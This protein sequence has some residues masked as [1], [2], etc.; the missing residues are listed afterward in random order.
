MKFILEFKSYKSTYN[1]GDIVLIEYWYLDE[2]DCP[3]ELF[4]KM[5]YTPVKI[6]EKISNKSFK[7]SHNIENSKIKNAPDEI[8]KN[9][10]IIDKVR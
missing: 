4:R 6:I 9:N 7:V 1:V 10:D 2:K 8:I 5:P 3:N